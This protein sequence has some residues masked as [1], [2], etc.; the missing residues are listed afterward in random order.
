MKRMGIL[1]AG[2]VAGIL[3]AICAWQAA[4]GKRWTTVQ[5]KSCPTF[6]ARSKSFPEGALSFTDPRAARES[7][8]HTCRLTHGV[9]PQA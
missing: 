4:G 9:S 2:S 6:A 5:G 7:G 8:A 1:G 3:L